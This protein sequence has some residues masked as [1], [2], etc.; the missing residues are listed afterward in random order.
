MAS[1]DVANTG[2]GAAATGPMSPKT[3]PTPAYNWQHVHADLEAGNYSGKYGADH[4][5]Y[6]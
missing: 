3:R 6:Q 5:A 2:A 1:I 4:T